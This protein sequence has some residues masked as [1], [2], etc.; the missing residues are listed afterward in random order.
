MT[1]LTSAFHDARVS[2]FGAFATMLFGVVFIALLYLR[3]VT[4]TDRYIR[5]LER[6][7]DAYEQVLTRS[8]P[9]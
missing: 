1:V 9:Q 2:T 4:Q 3:A 5:R 7:L 6:D 8:N